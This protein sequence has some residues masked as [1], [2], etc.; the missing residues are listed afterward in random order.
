MTVTHALTHEVAYGSLL[1]ERRRSLYA[2]VIDAIETVYADRLAEW[3]GQLAHH[4]VRGEVWRKAP[5]YFRPDP[6]RAFPSLEALPC[7]RGEHARAAASLQSDLTVAV[8]F[9]NFAFQVVTHFLLGQAYHALGDY[10]RAIG[11]LKRNVVSLEGDLLWGSFHLPAPASV[12]SHTWLAW[13]LAECG[14]FGEGLA[15]AAE[16]V[17]TAE[18]AGRP[19]GEPR[20]ANVMWFDLGINELALP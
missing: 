20:R 12:L 3:H 19:L 7:W 5:V 14:E 11:V 10:G 1:R 13:C 4:V 16:V 6:V 9:K 2:R 18:R 17:Q 8:E 15:V